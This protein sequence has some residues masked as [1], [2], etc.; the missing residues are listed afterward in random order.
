LFSVL[1]ELEA[2]VVV[3]IVAVFLHIVASLCSSAVRLPR[4]IGQATET[5]N[6]EAKAHAAEALMRRGVAGK[7]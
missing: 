7:G 1:G 3:Y 4:L 5:E 6:S 2:A